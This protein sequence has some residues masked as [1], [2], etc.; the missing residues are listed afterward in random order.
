M[1]GVD[2]GELERW[3]VDRL[4][5]GTLARSATSR[6]GFFIAGFKNSSPGPPLP[7]DVQFEAHAH[8]ELGSIPV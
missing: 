3:E 4:S 6:E 7:T 8:S 2:K 1:G 5:S